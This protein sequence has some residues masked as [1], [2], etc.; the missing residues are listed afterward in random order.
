MAKVLF[1]NGD[2]Y[3]D[4]NGVR[5]TSDE[6]LE[7]LKTVDPEAVKTFEA[8]V[9]KVKAERAKAEAEAKAVQTPAT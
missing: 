1:L 4:A 5:A 2:E 7:H 6:A 9:K 3:V 8:K